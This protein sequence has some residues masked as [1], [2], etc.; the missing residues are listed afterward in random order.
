MRQDM[1]LFKPIFTFI[2]LCFSCDRKQKRRSRFCL[3][4]GAFRRCSGAAGCGLTPCHVPFR[5]SGFALPYCVEILCWSVWQN[6]AR[7]SGWFPPSRFRVPRHFCT[8][9]N[10][11]ALDSSNS[12]FQTVGLDASRTQ[13][14]DGVA[15]QISLCETLGKLSAFNPRAKTSVLCIKLVSHSWTNQGWTC[16]TCHLFGVWPRMYFFD[17]SSAWFTVDGQEK[18]KTSR[19]RRFVNLLW[20]QLSLNDFGP[21]HEEKQ[22]FHD[23][24]TSSYDS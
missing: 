1:Q 8:V 19:K 15:E 11:L 13:K 20:S 10:S 7:T 9:L 18:I 12:R 21:K 24:T 5:A 3:V 4:S 22:T 16:M 2:A 6:A 17:G 14:D 23:C